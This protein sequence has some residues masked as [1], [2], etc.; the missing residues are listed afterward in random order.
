MLVS[1]LQPSAACTVKVC[2]RSSQ[3]EVEV[4][5][6]FKQLKRRLVEEGFDPESIA[7]PLY[8]LDEAAQSYISLTPRVY[9]LLSSGGIKL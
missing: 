9:G 5:S 3:T 1:G 8:V 4:T 6:T 2:L 7:D